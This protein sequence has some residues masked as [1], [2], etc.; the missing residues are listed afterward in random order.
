MVEPIG[1]DS[2][3]QKFE[4]DVYA[5]VKK[6]FSDLREDIRVEWNRYDEDLN[7]TP[8]VTIIG[9]CRCGANPPL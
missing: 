6:Y 3:W 4:N 5:T 1:Y 7:I 8:D 2:L 9:E